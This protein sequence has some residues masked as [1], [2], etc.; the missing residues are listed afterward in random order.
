MENYDLKRWEPYI[1]LSVK[2]WNSHCNN[3]RNYANNYQNYFLKYCQDFINK[4]THYK[5]N[6]AKMKEL[7]GRTS[8][9]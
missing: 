9:L 2:G 5:L 3:I 7:F 1:H 4:N 6:D 8:T